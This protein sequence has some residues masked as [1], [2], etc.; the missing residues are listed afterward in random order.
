MKSITNQASLFHS[1]TLSSRLTYYRTFISLLP[2]LKNHSIIFL[3]FSSF[4]YILLNC[5][6]PH[7]YTILSSCLKS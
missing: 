7:V 4:L 6:F 2:H 5:Y 1:K 3:P